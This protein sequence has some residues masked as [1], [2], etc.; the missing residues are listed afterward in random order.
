MRKF[1]QFFLVFILISGWFL[2]GCKKLVS[3]INTSPNNPI[4]VPSGSLLLGSEVN[5][6]FSLATQPAIFANLFSRAITGEKNQAR[7]YW[8][9]AINASDFDYDWTQIYTAP[10]VNFLILEN[11]VINEGNRVFLGVEQI[12]RAYLMSVITDLW[13][14]VPYT[15]VGSSLT[16]TPIYDKQLSIYSSLQDLLT[17]AIENL[18]SGS[19]GVPAGSDIFYNGNVSQWVQAANALKA[20]LY[21][22]IAKTARIYYDSAFSYAQKGIQQGNDWYGPQGVIFSQDANAWQ[23]FIYSA[24]IGDIDAD[25]RYTYGVQ[26]FFNRLQWENTNDMNTNDS[27]RF[28]F[29]YQI[30]SNAGFSSGVFYDYILNALGPGISGFNASQTGVMGGNFPIFTYAENLLIAA[31]SALNGT[32]GSTMALDYLNRYRAY[33]ATGANISSGYI[34][35][36]NLKYVPYVMSDFNQGGKAN[37]LNL[38]TVDSAMIENILEEK[39]ISLIGQIESFVDVTRTNNYLKIPLSPNLIVGGGLGTLP[40]RFLY[41]QVEINS[42]PNTPVQSTADFFRPTTANQNPYMVY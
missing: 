40:Q 17:Q 2:M 31:E 24:R 3:G 26:L 11:Q 12:N 27:A 25:S 16:T 5:M 19:G 42:N 8:S 29:S 10:Y 22:H 15:Q 41:P 34:T 38:S 28:A 21:L 36:S 35:P 4:A 37:R 39:Y 7:G 30:A 18:N 32:A 13:G 1:Y 20:R 33:L 9:Y 14:D 23:N 6:Q